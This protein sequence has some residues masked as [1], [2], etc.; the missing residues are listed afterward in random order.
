MEGYLE[1]LLDALLDTLKLV[2]ILL[3]VFLL[4]EFLEY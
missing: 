3:F 4:I 1:I 2:P